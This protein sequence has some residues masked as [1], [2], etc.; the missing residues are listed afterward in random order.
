MKKFAFLFLFL[1]AGCYSENKVVVEGGRP[2][3]VQIKGM[4]SALKV[5]IQSVDGCEYL[6]VYSA[7]YRYYRV[8]HWEKCDSCTNR[9]WPDGAKAAESAEVRELGTVY[10]ASLNIDGCEYFTV[11]KWGG[12]NPDDIVHRG[13][14]KKCWKKR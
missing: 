4:D 10:F 2:V 11:K 9:S 1:L 7:N 3:E 8:S 14:C 6:F 5:S 13:H 12:G